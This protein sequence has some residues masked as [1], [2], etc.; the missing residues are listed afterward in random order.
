M[1]FGSLCSGIEAASVAWGPF[2]W[3]AAWF[4]EIEAFPSAVLAHHYPTVPNLGDMTAVAALLRLGAIEAPD[5]LCGGTPCQAFSVAGLRASLDDARGNLTLTFCEI[6]NALDAR[7]ADLGKPPAVIVWENVPGVLSTSDNAFGCFL[8]ALAGEDGPVA[9]PGGKWLNAGRV[10]GPA[11][12]VA[13]RTLDAQYF[14]VAQRRRRVFVVASARD[15]FDPAAVLFES[16][17]L[18]RDTPPSRE[19]WQT[20]ADPAARRAGRS[21]GH[22]SHWNGG[23]RPPLSQA[24]QTR[25]GGI[26]ASNQ[27]LFEQGGAGL[28]PEVVG[29]IG[30]NTGP[31]GHG[32]GDFLNNQAV[33]AG[34]ILAFGG[35]RTSGPIEVSPALLGQ[36]GGGWKGDFETETFLTQPAHTLRGEGFDASEDGTGVRYAHYSHDYAHDRITDT[37]GVNPALTKAAYASGNLNVAV[38]TARAANPVPAAQVRRLTP[39]E[40][41]RLQGFP[42]DYTLIP[43]G[44]RVKPEKLDADYLKYQMRGNPRHLTRADIDRLAADGPRY[45]ALG[46]SWAVP[47]VRWIGLRVMA[48]LAVS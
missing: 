34:H 12:A 11:R 9:P 42:D 6:A 29:T 26:G 8:G 33:D 38:L 37:S 30:C 43:F 3:H 46:N 5:V 13:W 48:Q 27:E 39:R 10:L 4:S 22:N 41:E 1:N 17:G 18:R 23:P 16:Q 35:N 36:G 47:V 40:C 7:R 19:A 24:S 25:A 28:V 14:G 15:G 20:P 2:G 31:R 32:F 44:R 45:K 21:S